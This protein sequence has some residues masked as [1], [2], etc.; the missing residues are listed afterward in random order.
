MGVSVSTCCFCLC[1]CGLL[2]D[3][4]YLRN[5]V[6]VIVVVRATLKI[7]FSNLNLAVSEVK[8]VAESVCV[9]LS[10]VSVLEEVIG[11]FL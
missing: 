11:L 1:C 10:Q 7:A 8:C 5:A 2:F 9:Y 3:S 6:L 4:S